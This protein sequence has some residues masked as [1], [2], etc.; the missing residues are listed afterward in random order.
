MQDIG[1]HKIL[2]AGVAH[3]KAHT[4]I[5]RPNAA[6]D[7]TQTIVASMSAA[8]LVFDLARCEVDLVVQDDHIFGFK[9]VKSHCG[10][11]GLARVV[12]ERLGLEQHGA[13]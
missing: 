5:V 7:R 1:R 2:A 6:V 11:N 13:V 8:N 10:L 4:C 9:F 12:H 3:A